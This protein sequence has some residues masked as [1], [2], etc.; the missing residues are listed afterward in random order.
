MSPTLLRQFKPQYPLVFCYNMFYK[1][2]NHFA[3]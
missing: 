2:A 3:P 1:F